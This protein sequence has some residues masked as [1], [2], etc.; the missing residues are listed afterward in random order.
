MAPTT[1]VFLLE[2]EVLKTGNQ[3]KKKKKKGCELRENISQYLHWKLSYTR[4]EKNIGKLKKYSPQEKKGE[5]KH[6]T[7]AGGLFPRKKNI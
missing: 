6:T 4:L 1:S 2:S 7:K 3:G 5:G